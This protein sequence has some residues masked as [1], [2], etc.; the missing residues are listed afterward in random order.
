MN[1]GQ[2]QITLTKPQVF[3]WRMIVFLILAAFLVLILYGQMQAAFMSNPGLNGL[4]IG[5]L[6]IGIVY[7]IGQVLRLYPEIRWVNTL[8]SLKSGYSS[9]KLPTLLLPMANMLGDRSAG[10]LTLSTIAM[11]SILDSIGSR[12]DEA[13]DTSRYLVG[14]LIFLGLLGTFWGLLDTIGSVG[15]TIAALDT[16][17]SDSLVVF[18][19]L[20]SGLEAP[21]KGMGTAFASSLFG[22]AGSLVLGFLDL[23]SSQA[24]NRFYNELEEWLSGITELSVADNTAQTDIAQYMQQGIGGLQR[25]MANLESRIAANAPNANMLESADD[26][27]REL[28]DIREE[29]SFVRQWMTEQAGQNAELVK[30]LQDL[31]KKIN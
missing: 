31:S 27:E 20:K 12:L 8:R 1:D 15:K 7:S 4:I 17:G 28:T 5:V 2:Y 25:Q 13:R 21:L 16:S 19:E 11:R 30:V 29:Q 24:H 3:L 9:A 23:Q 26:V 10:H 6:F 18:E 22:L 14:L